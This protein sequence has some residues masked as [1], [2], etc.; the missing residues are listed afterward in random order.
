MMNNQLNEENLLAGVEHAPPG[1][2][3]KLHDS[4]SGGDEDYDDLQSAGGMSVHTDVDGNVY[5]MTQEKKEE[6]AKAE[7]KAV[8]ML[9][10]V[11]IAVLVMSAVGVSLAVFFYMRST[12]DHEFEAQFESD[13]LK[14]LE[15]IGSTL[16]E[17][18][19][20][21]DAFIVKM[22]AYARYS[23]STWPYVTM[24]SF[25]IHATKLLRLSKAFQLSIGHVVEPENRIDWEIYADQHKGWIQESADI[26]SRDEDWDKKI[27]GDFST[28]YSIYGFGGPVIE[29]T[30]Y[31]N[32]FMPAW[33]QAPVVADAVNGL[34]V[35]WDQWR[36][37]QVA[38]QM[39]H[40][41]DTQQVVTGVFGAIVTN[42]SDPVDVMIAGLGQDWVSDYIG[43]D[44]DPAEP[45]SVITYPM[46][47]V[48]DSVRI[49]LS[50]KQPLVGVVSFS[51]FWRDLFKDILP[52]NSKGIVVVVKHSCPIGLG[53]TTGQAITYQIDG[54]DTTYLGI[55]DLHDPQY[56]NLGRSSLLAD[57]AITTDSDKASSYTGI[58][59][60]DGFCP[61]MV[62]VYPS[63]T[64][65]DEYTTSDP[66]IFTVAAAMIFVFTS[67][68]FLVYDCLVARRQRIVLQRALASGAIVSSLFPEK[69]RNQLYEENRGNQQKESD[70]KN[71]VKTDDD[72]R[73][74][75]QIAD[76]FEET[77]I[78]FADLV[79]FTAWSGRRTP[80]EVFELL[81][82]LYAA[83]DK[84]AEKRGVFKV[85][86]IGDCYV[87]VTGIPNPQPDHAVIM[88]QFARDCVIRMQQ[89]T[90]STELM[91]KLGDDTAELDMRVG[92]HSGPT[93]AGILRGQ[94]SRFQLFG[95]TVNTAARMESN[96]VPGR[97]HV[98]Q[99]TA[100]A[101]IVAKKGHWLTSR[102]DKVNAKGKGEMQTYWVQI[103][104]AKSASHTSTHVT[105]S[106]LEAP[107]DDEERQ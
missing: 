36:L 27:E 68:V 83:F 96:G 97:I 44:E 63:Q 18:L 15:A 75:K 17:T 26:Q 22:I 5:H 53:E 7:D 41:I 3:D 104:S 65:Q 33:Q 4:D 84:I 9:R 106:V 11:V 19:G 81:E 74:T 105:N 69:V 94:K 38:I 42:A 88:S 101:L 47:D 103:K 40:S 23:N 21:T 39:K 55:G 89:L 62:H 32:N 14:V 66:I 58:P 35:N 60:S 82:T 10:L 28:S 77:T 70:M 102:E 61:K 48:L 76:L 86:T 50:K 90:T 72:E 2:D 12:E 85:E 87:A 91:K 25:A 73:G 16:D 92:L 99:S 78:L 31:M 49:D 37:P 29:P 8:F 13:S 98:S 56:D 59:F 52:L 67:I 71:F 45:M 107:E 1:D 64:M 57:L 79:G 46:Y 80:S 20:A 95:D 6:I 54:R 93:T 30:L 24:P 34:P 100:D 51:L 43:P